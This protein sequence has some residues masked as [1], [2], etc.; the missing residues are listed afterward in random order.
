MRFTLNCSTNYMK[1]IDGWVC[2][3][4]GDTIVE[5]W[6]YTREDMPKF[7]ATKWRCENEEMIR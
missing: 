2:R 3:C 6:E 1:K 5:E 7:I 4:G